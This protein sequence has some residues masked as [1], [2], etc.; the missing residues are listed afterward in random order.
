MLRTP[1]SAALQ[2]ETRRGKI[3]LLTVYFIANK[4]ESEFTC[5]ES[6]AL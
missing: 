5:V 1:K 2:T 6:E 4:I 3:I